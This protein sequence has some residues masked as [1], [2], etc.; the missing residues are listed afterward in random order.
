MEKND[1]REEQ[2]IIIA[3]GEKSSVTTTPPNNDL[4]RTTND[5]K[6]INL[7]LRTLRNIS[8]AYCNSKAR[9]KSK[10]SYYKLCQIEF[11]SQ[12]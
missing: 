2:R 12:T 8:L 5:G 4:A 11:S 6:N 10:T 3:K 1:T 9:L 7:H